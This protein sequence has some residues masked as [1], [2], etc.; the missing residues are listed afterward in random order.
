MI[1][2][3]GITPRGIRRPVQPSLREKKEEENRRAK[4]IAIEREKEL[5]KRR[6]DIEAKKKETHR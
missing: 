1:I 2:E 6:A 4:E 3:H 5:E